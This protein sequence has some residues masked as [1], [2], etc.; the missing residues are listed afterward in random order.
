MRDTFLECYCLWSKALAAEDIRRHN[1]VVYPSS[2]K[3]VVP[4]ASSVMIKGGMMLLMRP[5]P[6]Q[7]LHILE[8]YLL[9]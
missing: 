5:L 7:R 4:V 6:G 2:K 3:H 8:S 1:G 9:L